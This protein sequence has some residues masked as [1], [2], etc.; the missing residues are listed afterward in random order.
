MNS[1]FDGGG[2]KKPKRMK[3]SSEGMNDRRAAPDSKP[4][5]AKT[6]QC[7]L[8]CECEEGS[9]APCQCGVCICVPELGLVY[10]I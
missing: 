10:S 9:C 6:R 4:D 5:A 3:N 8:K 7:M 1:L 2:G